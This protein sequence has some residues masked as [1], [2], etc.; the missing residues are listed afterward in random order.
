[1]N[2]IKWNQALALVAM[3]GVLSACGSDSDN[4]DTPDEVTSANYEI[5]IK[6]ITNSQPLSPVAVLMHSQPYR[7]WSIGSEASV[8]LE[9]LA[10]GG[11]NAALLAL[12]DDT[13]QA[14]ASG[15]GAIMPGTSETLSVTLNNPTAD[16]YLS[17][18]TMLVNTNDAFIGVTGLQIANLE[19]GESTTLSLAV[20]DAGTEANS[21]LVNTIPGQMGE[22]FNAE[23]DDTNRVTRHPGVVGS[24]DGHSE[25][26]LNSQHKF[27]NPAATLTVT[28]VN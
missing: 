22:G 11:S 5:T 9:E 1:M 4:D 2:K 16:T 17:V 7:V 8:A 24:D 15:A 3:T 14:M 12:T 20:Y 19:M 6:N 13:K 26:V 27:D 28:R 21:E 18:S 25:S 23:R 10:E